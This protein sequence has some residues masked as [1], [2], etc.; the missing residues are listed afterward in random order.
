MLIIYE[1]I[2]LSND[3]PLSPF[4][5]SLFHSSVGKFILLKT[6]LWILGLID[7]GNSFFSFSNGLIVAHEAPVL[8]PFLAL[9][10]VC[11]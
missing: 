3:F 10:K 11:Y 5:I 2:L 1:E 6:D 9:Q 8:D 7:G 4:R